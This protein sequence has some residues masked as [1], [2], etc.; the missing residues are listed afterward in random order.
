[1]ADRSDGAEES[2]GL[3]SGG[4]SSSSLLAAFSRSSGGATTKPNSYHG[5]DTT[6][7]AES[8]LKRHFGDDA[9]RT[10]D[11]DSTALFIEELETRKRTHGEGGRPTLAQ[12]TL[13]G[14]KQNLLPGLVLQL[15][16]TLVVVGYYTYEPAATF[17]NK[18][19]A[20]KE[21]SGYLFSIVSTAF[22]GGVLP[23][24]IILLKD[25]LAAKKE[26]ERRSAAKL[27]RQQS[28]AAAKSDYG[29]FIEEDEDDGEAA[30]AKEEPST[31]LLVARFCFYAGFM[32][33]RG[34]EVDA[35]YRL[36]GYIFGEGN[37]FW[38]IFIKVV[39]DQFVWNP[40]YAAPSNSTTLPFFIFIYDFI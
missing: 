31:G 22:F 23:Y 2:T 16:G 34:M 36:Q 35:F 33:Y 39:V 17:L 25:H 27:K 37:D 11:G 38:T 29:D 5:L 40:I 26:K 21:Q 9:K 4:K 20:V 8:D 7:D 24:L 10:H 13:Q 3:L 6:Y 18:I 1:M 19:A 28:A 32:G 30:A 14:L 15:I 12:A